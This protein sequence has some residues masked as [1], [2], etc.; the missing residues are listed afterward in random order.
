MHP[1]EIMPIFTRENV[2]TETKSY[3][4]SQI[5]V[6]VSLKEFL[7]KAKTPKDGVHSVKKVEK[8]T[9]KSIEN[10]S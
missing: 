7:V 6:G 8:G 2:A 4:L 1:E 5:S 9:K 10:R 3:T